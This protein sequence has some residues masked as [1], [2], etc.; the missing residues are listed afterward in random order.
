METQH[1]NKMLDMVHQA[2][3]HAFVN[4]AGVMTN[5]MQNAMLDAIAEGASLGFQD[6]VINNLMLL[7]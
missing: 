4:N 5:S 6:L 1:E 3:G 7:L 2:V